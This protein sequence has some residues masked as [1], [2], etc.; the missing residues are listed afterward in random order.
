MGLTH[1]KDLAVSPNRAQRDWRVKTQDWCWGQGTGEPLGVLGVPGRE[2]WWVTGTAGGLEVKKQVEWH[3][4]RTGVCTLLTKTY[5]N[6]VQSL[7][8]V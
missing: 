5:S 8:R 6:F 4:W 3:H 7:S 1:R 2:Y